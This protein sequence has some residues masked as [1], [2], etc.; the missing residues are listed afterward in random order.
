MRW[1]QLGSLLVPRAPLID[2]QL[3][4]VLPIVL[5]H[6]GPMLVDERLHAV[7]F[8]KQ[9]IVLG[10]VKIERVP[11]CGKPVVGPA[12]SKIPGVMMKAKTIDAVEESWTFF[13]Y[14]REEPTR[15]VE[16]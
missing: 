12:E 15:P 9:F 14:L 7:G 16:V 1:M 8:T 3:D 6:D 2:D 13:S 11:L 10:G 5:A 4:A